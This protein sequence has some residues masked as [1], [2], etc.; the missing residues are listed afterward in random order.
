M[1]VPLF[2]QQRAAIGAAVGQGV[3]QGVAAGLPGAP[4]DHRTCPGTRCVP[5]YCGTRGVMSLFKALQ[6]EIP[7]PAMII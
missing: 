4:G 1:A 7:A 6:S 3:G 5:P 2:P